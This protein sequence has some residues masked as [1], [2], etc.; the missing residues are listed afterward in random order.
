[1]PKYFIEMGQGIVV[2]PGIE[3]GICTSPLY[4]CCFITGINETAGRVGAFHYPSGALK[5]RY[6]LVEV[7]GQP[8]RDYIR[9]AEHMQKKAVRAAMR[10]WIAAL[11][12]TKAHVIYG[13]L[14]VRTD[15]DGDLDWADHASQKD[16]G[17]VGTFIERECG[18]AT[19]IQCDSSAALVR[20]VYGGA[21]RHR[22]FVTGNQ[23]Q[24]SRIWTEFQ[25]AFPVNLARLP[26]GQHAGYTLFGQ[27][28]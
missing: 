3:V 5:R 7:E 27:A 4:T 14:C 25:T 23:H 22:S 15:E 8:R 24:V 12:P 13:P 20:R 17:K 6:G 21:V 9:D 16:V 28:Q 19:T 10:S 11:A 26:A 18:V 1:M 2:G